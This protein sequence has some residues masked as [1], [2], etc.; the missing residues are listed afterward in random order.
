MTQYPDANDETHEV[1]PELLRLLKTLEPLVV[2]P[3]LPYF[4]ARMWHRIT[5]RQ[6]RRRVGWPLTLRW[7]PAWTLVPVAGLLLSLGLNGWFGYQR[8][9]LRQE[10]DAYKTRLTTRSGNTN[11]PLEI[12]LQAAQDEAAGLFTEAIEAYEHALKVSGAPVDALLRKLARV[13]VKLGRY[14]KA[15]E[16]ATAA[17]VVAPN[18]ARAYWYRGQ[19]AKGL[20]ES[21]KALEDWQQA[22]RLGDREAQQTLR[23]QG[24]SW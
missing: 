7:H 17:L 4:R 5:Q 24:M 16:T 2:E 6:E 9:S 15:H 20:G 8:S 19:A 18:D 21:T 22:A 11:I 3:S 1:P 10:L 23:A 14:A 12:E 13:N